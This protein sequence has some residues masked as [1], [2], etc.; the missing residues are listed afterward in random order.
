[1]DRAI[2]LFMKYKEKVEKFEKRKRRV[3]DEDPA[4]VT[5]YHHV[6]LFERRKNSNSFFGF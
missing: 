6:Y 5:V 1:M 2:E 3:E 4:V